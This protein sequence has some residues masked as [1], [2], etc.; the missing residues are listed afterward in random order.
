MKNVSIKLTR[1]RGG[2]YSVRAIGIRSKLESP[3]TAA[4][5]VMI[6]T[7]RHALKKKMTV[8]IS[9]RGR[10]IALIITC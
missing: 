6:K 8:N 2:K 4:E 5:V 10:K 3:L 1:H 7:I 9:R